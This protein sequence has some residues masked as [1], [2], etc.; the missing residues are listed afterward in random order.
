MNSRIPHFLEE[1]LSFFPVISPPVT[2]SE[3]VAVKFSS[4][5][6]PLP[7]SVVNET[8]SRWDSLDE[9]TELVPCFQMPTEGQYYALI[10]WKGSLLSYEYILATVSHDGIIISKKVIAGTLSD[11]NKVI[12]SVASIDEDMC[13]Y[14]VAGESDSSINNYKPNNTTA[15]R[16]EILPD[17]KI[18]ST[19][20]DINQWE[21]KEK[22]KQT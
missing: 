1:I 9:L 22:E 10:W 7:L 6:K 19:Q 16:F 3:E 8:F 18:Q 21:E 15:Y 20:E 11:G 13:V 14:T 2:L 4:L 5:N 17:G 12:R